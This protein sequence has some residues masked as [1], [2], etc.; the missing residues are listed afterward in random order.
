MTK[1]TAKSTREKPVKPYDDFPLFPHATGRWA[2]K[3]RG[4]LEYFGSWEDGWQKA[5]ENYQAWK[6]DLYAGRRPQRH[7]TGRLSIRD[8]CNAF[9]ESK[10]GKVQ[11]G[12]I[13][14]ETLN[15][16]LESI[17]RIIRVFGKTVAVEDL[18][19][20]DFTRLRADTA[21]HRKTPEGLGNELNSCRVVFNFAVKNHLV[22]NVW[23]GD[24]FRRPPRAVIRR[25]RAQRRQVEGEMMFEA[26]ELTALLESAPGQYKAMI[27]LAINCGLAGASIGQLPKSAID[28][29]R[30]WLNFPRYKTGNERQCQL[31][32]ETVSA[33]RE[34]LNQISAAKP[35]HEH[36]AFL[37]RCG[38]GWDKGK[39]STLS[40]EFRKLLDEVGI[41][42][43][44]RGFRAIRHTFKTI[45]GGSRDQVAVDHIMGHEANTMAAVYREHIDPERLQAVVDHVHNW[46]WPPQPQKKQQAKKKPDRPRAPKR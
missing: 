23:F 30:E 14:Q 25:A 43:K 4:Q 20:D 1:S 36:L 18:H 22:S 31:W 12:E 46:L 8:L 42:R 7:N 44:G 26:K 10:E 24:D 37:T 15:D 17:D 27:L 33:L 29:E 32:P 13:K 40:H 28:L 39:S 3:I 38:T 11:T 16:Y 6:D 2:K 9:R 5:L 41:Y 19:R 45:A 34:S 35:G 21:E